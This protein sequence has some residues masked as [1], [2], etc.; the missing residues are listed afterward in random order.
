M[1][2]PI[3]VKLCGGALPA[4]MALIVMFYTAST[5]EPLHFGVDRN[6]SGILDL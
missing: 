4:W 6:V 3:R 1:K 2:G 5:F